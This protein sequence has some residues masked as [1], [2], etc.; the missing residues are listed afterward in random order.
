MKSWL[1]MI[2]SRSLSALRRNRLDREFDDELATHLELL[3]DEGRAAGLS[4]EDARR[5]AMRKLWR[6]DW[7]RESHRDQ[8]GLPFLDRLTQDLRYAVRGLSKTPAFTVIVVLS[9]ALGIGAN[10]ALFSLVD[11][12]L[13]RSLP[14]RDANRLVRVQMTMAGLGLRKSMTGFPKD[15]F[16]D[17]RANAGVLEDVVGYSHMDRPTVTLE[18]SIE[19]LRQVD[20]VSENFFR[21]LG[22]S[23]IIGRAP[24]PGED[25]AVVISSA[26]WR[27]R[28]GGS[29]SVLG[30]AI[31]IEGRLYSIVG[32]APPRFFGMSLDNTVD[33]W[34]APRSPGA[35]DM[36]GRVKPGVTIE[37]AQ[38]AM[39][40]LLGR[41]GQARPG[42][43][44]A[45][46]NLI[47]ELVPAGRGF[48]QLRAQYER[49]LQALC[50]LVTLV[51]LITCSNV[52]NLLMV[53][54]SGRRREVTIRVALGASRS[55][56]IAQY[57]IESLVLATIGGALGLM[58]ARWGVSLVLSMLPL[59]QIP[60]GLAF[61]VD[62]RMLVFTAALSVVSA[63][64]F[65]LAPAW[66]AADVDL[67]SALRPGHGITS[68][69]AA[70]RLRSA[71]VGCQV[72]LSVL[73]LVAAGLF[74]QTLRNLTRLDMG[75]NPDRLIQVSVDTRSAGYG[76]GQVAPLA[77]LLRDRLSA[78]PG[79]ESV[80]IIRN[81][82]L[83]G[84]SRARMD[85]P[86]VTVGRD[87][88]WDAA[89][90][91]PGFFETMRIPIVRGRP[92][93]DGDVEQERML[94]ALSESFVKRY[95]PTTDPIGKQ[96][97][98]N[99]E[100][101]AIVGDAKLGTVRSPMG[102]MMYFVSSRQPDRFNGIEVR[103]AGNAET[104]AQG[105]RQVIHAVNPRLFIDLKPMRVQIDD[106]L[107]TERLV[108][109]ISAFFSVLGLLLASIGIFGVASSAV[110]QK[111]NE[112]GI[113]MALGASRWSIVRESLRET[114]LVVSV[115]L[116]AGLAAAVAAVQVS[117]KFIA[118]LLFGLTATDA[119]NIALAI[120][121]MAAVAIAACILPTRHATRIDPL[122]A[123]RHE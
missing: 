2:W 42:K 16:D 86:G 8:R 26:F 58:F 75:F 30:R 74:V 14:A 121:V 12:L 82:V 83:R 22:L 76:R 97:G 57:F 78:V 71:L 122:V 117:S 110:A 96:V 55:R 80:A 70:R 84:L 50:V 87:E 34:M 32:V 105:I 72:A 115:G 51:L 99:L 90:V 35:Q 20:Q 65:G 64:L 63:L 37:Q 11:S 95:Y 108:A 106:S 62:A 104:V 17:V 114:V 61:A 93:T 111:T 15:V 67:T 101:V 3:I 119:I 116:L 19:P 113:R 94:V 44:P 7:L 79:V 41:I 118:D 59:P 27:S 69:A 18:G 77:R 89:D 25:T 33:I 23:P 5:Q 52:G 66:R 112:L 54:S 1:H 24:A 31:A 49:P 102:P 85:L 38:T 40:A 13:I 88:A 53:R 92:F 4:A 46:P 9:L 123:I 68:P 47:T 56:V 10:T 120:A 36:V 21:D 98:G 45:D 73:L 107:A 60:A 100:V 6:P 48:S 28:F 91:G 29:P 43:I 109:A 103:T 81:P 39:H